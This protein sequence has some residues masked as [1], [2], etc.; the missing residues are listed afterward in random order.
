MLLI[1][2][3]RIN[4]GQD[5]I[6]LCKE[7]REAGIHFFEKWL[8]ISP[9]DYVNTNDFHKEMESDL[10]SKVDDWALEKLLKQ[11]LGHITKFFGMNKAETKTEENI[12]EKIP[13]YTHVD[14]FFTNKTAQHIGDPA[15]AKDYYEGIRKNYKI[16]I[17]LEGIR[18]KLVKG[19]K[20]P[21]YAHEILEDAQK[22]FDEGG[23]EAKNA[24]LQETFK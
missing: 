23:V 11:S 20:R 5:S 18:K 4:Q 7:L 19:I 9:L 2:N 1:K 13:P 15:S 8:S 17:I 14:V 21:L 10:T 3:L 6:K 12:I 22:A 16:D 24:Y